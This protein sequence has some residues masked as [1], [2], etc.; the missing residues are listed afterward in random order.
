[1]IPQQS[2]CFKTRAHDHRCFAVIEVVVALRSEKGVTLAQA[3]AGWSILN[4][5]SQQIIRL[6]DVSAPDV[7]MGTSCSFF[8]LDKCL[9]VCTRFYRRPP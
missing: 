2:F 1:M 3:G 4:I 6:N 9:S 8:G 7:V 5:F